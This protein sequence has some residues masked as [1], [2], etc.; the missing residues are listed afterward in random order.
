MTTHRKKRKLATEFSSASLNNP[1]PGSG[2]PRW[3]ANDFE[4]KVYDPDGR[5][6]R[7]SRGYE[8]GSA[9]SPK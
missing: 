1:D 8:R 7:R 3:S 9:I 2:S 6:G 4:W 5:D